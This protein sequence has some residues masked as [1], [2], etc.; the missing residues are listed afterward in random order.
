MQDHMD[1]DSGTQASPGSGAG[2]PAAS[3]SGSDGVVRRLRRAPRP[4]GL[5]LIAVPVVATAGAIGLPALAA[6]SGPAGSSRLVAAAPATPAAFSRQRHATPSPSASR[7]RPASSD[8]AAFA[9]AGYGYQ[10]AV[11]LARLWGHRTSPYDAKGRAGE[12]LLGGGTLPTRPGQTAATVDAEAALDAYFNNGY[13]YDDALALAKKWHT[14]AVAG[15]LSSVKIGAGRNLLAGRPVGARPQGLRSTTALLR[16]FAGGGYGYDDAVLLAR[17]WGEGLTPA[18]AKA[19][20]GNKLLDGFP[21]P[22]RPG[23]TAATVSEDAATEAYFSHGYDYDDAV[24]LATLWHRGQDGDDLGGVKA[25][26]G[27]KLLAGITLPVHA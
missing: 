2:A 17:L 20:A 12:Q 9:R 8:V 26:A 22:T 16:A 1:H 4:L 6:A 23:Q 3:G 13:D 21:L 11:L 15:D 25:T 24:K 10:D 14:K 27:R 19:R 18:D 5:V 7:H